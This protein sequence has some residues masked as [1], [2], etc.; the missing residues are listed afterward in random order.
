MRAIFAVFALM[1]VM[2]GQASAGLFGFGDQDPPRP[3]YKGDGNYGSGET[4]RAGTFY[5]GVVMYARAVTIEGPNGTNNGRVAGAALGALAASKVGNGNGRTAAM[6]VGGL[7][8]AGAGGVVGQ[9]VSEDQATEAFVK[10]EDGRKISVVQI[11]TQEIRPGDK[12]LVDQSATGNWRVISL[13][14]N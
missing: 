1:F 2:T 10:L 7:M 8:G 12:V 5:E 14:S 11:M 6:I 4:L 13:A 9:A 3:V